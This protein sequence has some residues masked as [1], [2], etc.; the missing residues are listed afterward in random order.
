M[1]TRSAIGIKRGNSVRA[2]RCNYD[3]HLDYVGKILFENYT[4]E[5]IVEKLID[6]GDMSSLG[7]TIESTDYYSQRRGE[8]PE[9]YVPVKY[10]S[11]SEFANGES[12]EFADAEYI[13]LFI[14]DRWY[15]SE[16]ECQ[17]NLLTKDMIR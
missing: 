16:G 3:G 8:D 9:L 12:S 10:D 13:Y 11:V 7:E 5:D 6:G 15:V 17:F 1:G 4:T 14:N 2:V